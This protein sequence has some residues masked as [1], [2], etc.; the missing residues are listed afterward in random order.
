[1]YNRL[2]RLNELLKREVSCLLLREGDFKKE[3]LVTVTRVKV[4]SDLS[5]ARVYI[6]I[7]PEEKTAPI[8]DRLKKRIYFL[9]QKINKR[10]RIKKGP[11]I[12]FLADK[13]L[14]EASRVEELLEEIKSR[15]I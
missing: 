13:K 7:I 9:Q 6:S 11:K 4:T 14:K 12:V 5:E 10:I 8:I 2:D 3:A 1:M 15:T